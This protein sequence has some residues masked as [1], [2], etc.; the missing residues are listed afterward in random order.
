MEEETH[1]E[2]KEGTCFTAKEVIQNKNICV[3][4]NHD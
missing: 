4:Y 2:T 3:Y 1:A